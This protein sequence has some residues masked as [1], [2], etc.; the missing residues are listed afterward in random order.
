MVHSFTRSTF[1]GRFECLW[2]LDLHNVLMEYIVTVVVRDKSE[3]SWKKKYFVI[4]LEKSRIFR[5]FRPPILRT[6][7]KSWSIK[8]KQFIFQEKNI[9]NAVCIRTLVCIHTL[10]SKLKILIFCEVHLSLVCYLIRNGGMKSNSFQK[11]DLLT[12]CSPLAKFYKVTSVH[13]KVVRFGRLRGSGRFRATPFFSISFDYSLAVQ[14]VD[15]NRAS[16]GQI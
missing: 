6:N 2:R 13:W 14:H 3:K 10:S 1:V 8:R 9:H 16:T 4:F 15:S 11:R 7:G 5:Y 12:H